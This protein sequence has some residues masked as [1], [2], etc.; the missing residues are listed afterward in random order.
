MRSANQPIQPRRGGIR[1]VEAL[2]PEVVKRAA[3][4]ASLCLCCSWTAPPILALARKLNHI[5]LSPREI[6]IILRTLKQNA[7]CNFLVFGMG[8]DSPL[9]QQANRGGHTV[10]IEDD[11]LWLRRVQDFQPMITAFLVEYGTRKSE[12]RQLLQNPERLEMKLP[13]E[14]ERE[15]WDVVLIDGPHGST[16]SNPGR[17]KSIFLGARLVRNEGTVFVHDCDRIVERAYCDRF[18]GTPNFIEQVQKL[19]HYQMR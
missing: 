6:G 1:Q 9:W 14:I 2:T 13:D 5:Q 16:D 11:E 10:F 3:R 8:N 18:L 12:W 19:R 4:R 7:P 15:R 17:M